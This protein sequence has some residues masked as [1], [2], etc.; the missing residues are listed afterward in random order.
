MKKMIY[1]VVFLFLVLVFGVDII[2]AKDAPCFD[3]G[4]HYD[5]TWSKGCLNDK[6]KN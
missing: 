2:C 1:I 5:V 4:I 3:D 6:I